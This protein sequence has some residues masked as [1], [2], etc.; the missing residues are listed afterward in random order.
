MSWLNS[1]I[2]P[3]ISSIIGGGEDKVPQNLW[4][5]CPHCQ[6]MSYKKDLE[7]AHYICPQCHRHLPLDTEKWLDHLFGRGNWKEVAFPLAIKDPLKF[8]DK[9]SY[10]DRLKEAMNR[11]KLV[12]CLRVGEGVIEGSPLVVAAFD[13]TFM[14][15]SMGVSAGNAIVAACGRAAARKCPLLFVTASGGARMQ[16]GILSLMQ[17]P[18]TLAALANLRRMN[19]AVIVLLT[20]P[21]TGGVSASFATAGDVLLAEPQATI[22]FAGARVIQDTIRQKLPK[23]FQTAESLLKQ[24][25]ID[26]IVPR[27][28][29]VKTLA[30]LLFML[31]PKS[32]FAKRWKR[33]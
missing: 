18:R 25:H 19:L 26:A 10:K 28:E 24:G 5:A 3:R 16:E 9:K 30:N 22:G 20:N 6:K 8:R 11:T 32:E 13:F 33:P 15:G 4:L 1:L 31:A 12:D 27:G 7:M 29:L 14:G 21:T 17:M 2:R 23:G